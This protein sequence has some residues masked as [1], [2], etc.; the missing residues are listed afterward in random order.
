MKIIYVSFND[1][2]FNLKTH[3]VYKVGVQSQNMVFQS[4]IFK[5]K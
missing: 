1:Q 4:E 5:I 2:N 3:N